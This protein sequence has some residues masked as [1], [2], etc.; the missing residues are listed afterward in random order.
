MGPKED[1]LRTPQKRKLQE[2]QG[3]KESKKT[4]TIQHNTIV[5]LRRQLRDFKRG[6]ER[7]RKDCHQLDFRVDVLEKKLDIS[8]QRIRKLET[9]AE[10]NDT[11]QRKRTRLC[12]RILTRKQREIKKLEKALSGKRKVDSNIEHLIRAQREEFARSQESSSSDK[13]L[14]SMIGQSGDLPKP[15]SSSDSD[16]ET[17]STID[18]IEEELR[19]IFGEDE[20]TQATQAKAGTSR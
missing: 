12:S 13:N 9:E 2:T 8:K 7:L 16:S 6:N 17:D 11:L 3:V 20:L 5:E 19:K 1:R 4:I 14:P 10:E 15:D 18:S